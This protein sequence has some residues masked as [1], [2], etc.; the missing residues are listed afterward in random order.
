[1]IIKKILFL[2]INQFQTYSI[3]SKHLE[4][5]KINSLRYRGLEFDQSVLPILQYSP[6]CL[7]FGHTHMNH[8]QKFF[9]ILKLADSVSNAKSFLSDFLKQWLNHLDSLLTITCTS[10][11]EILQ[12]TLWHFSASSNK[13]RSFMVVQIMIDLVIQFFF[14]RTVKSTRDRLGQMSLPGNGVLLGDQVT[15]VQNDEMMLHFL[16]RLTTG[17][18]GVTDVD[19]F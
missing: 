11:S 1:M 14:P 5:H 4:K 12:Q 15:M 17:A 3:K 13:D 2:K 8:S 18:N 6:F 16:L 10:L 19:E 9:H 7:L